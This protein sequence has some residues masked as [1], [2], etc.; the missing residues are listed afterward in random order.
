MTIQTSHHLLG[1]SPRFQ[2]TTVQIQKI[3]RVDATVHIEGE[4]GTG[5][6]LAARAIH[7]LGKR[8]DGPFIPVNC[9]AL[10]ETL[11]ESELFGHE[12]GAFTDAKAA[13]AGLVSEA[14]GGTLFLDEVDALS[15]KAQAALL[16]FLQDQTYRRVGGGATR[17]ADVRIVAASNANLHKLVEAGQF[18]RD[19]L[20]RLTVLSL[21]MP[22]LRERSGDALELAE[23]FLQR[24]SHQYR[25]TPK[26]LHADSV[27]F[28]EQYGWPG[29]VRELENVV[30]REFLMSDDGLVRLGEASIAGFENEQEDTS[31]KTAKARAVADFERRYVREILQRADGNLTRAARLAGQ[32]RSAFGKLA[33]KHGLHQ[34]AALASAITGSSAELGD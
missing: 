26:R 9:G 31:F 13:T 15:L 22:A 4:T 12:R 24:L 34:L 6:E 1:S 33:R 29:N 2:K 20:Y 23:T 25:V 19:L 5:K 17:Q 3:A 14:N 11:I 8:C 10:P 30:H 21:R 27:V 7:Y 16:R 32:E 28:I 18:R